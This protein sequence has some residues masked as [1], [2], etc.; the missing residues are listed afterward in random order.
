MIVRSHLRM[1]DVN[2]KGGHGKKMNLTDQIVFFSEWINIFEL[3]ICGRQI[4]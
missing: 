1:S 4:K 3:S 2:K